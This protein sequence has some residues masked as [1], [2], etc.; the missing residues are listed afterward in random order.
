MIF[1]R[2]LSRSSTDSIFVSKVVLKSMAFSSFLRMPDSFS[3]TIC[4]EISAIVSELTPP[5]P[6]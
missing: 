5:P 1:S 6:P 4:S 2:R 3:A